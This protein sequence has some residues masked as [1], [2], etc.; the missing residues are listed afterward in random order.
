MKRSRQQ[1]KADLMNKAEQLIDRLLDWETQADRP[2]LTQIED[3]VLKLR[4]EM[5]QEMAETLLDEQSERTPVPG[6]AC[7]KCGKEMHYK[8]Q[9][10]KR[11]ESRAGGLEVERGYYVC[12]ECGETIFPPGSPTGV[13]QPEME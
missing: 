8:G 13:E 6:P 5:G 12:A 9:R 3:I 4:K 11:V 7:P 2:N 10:K 1:K